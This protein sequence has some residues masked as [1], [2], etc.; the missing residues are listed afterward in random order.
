MG[1][2]I[3]TE[4]RAGIDAVEADRKLLLDRAVKM[5]QAYG[6]AL[7]SFD[8][9]A[10]GAL[11][12]AVA[13]SAGFE[14]LIAAK[15]LICAGAILRLHLDTAARFVAG[16]LV[17]SPHEFAMEVLKGSPIN[18]IC[19]RS[20]QKMTDQYLISY[21]ANEYDGVKELY[22]ETCDYVHFSGTHLHSAI[23]GTS[24]SGKTVHF[25]ISPSDRAL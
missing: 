23:D 16:F 6:G 4:V 10:N 11:N 3:S 20:G 14:T 24:N 19:D 12:R 2:A 22:E 25:K 15:N 1:D 21:L 13:L 18:K 8:I 7:Y 5:L 17:E 9:F